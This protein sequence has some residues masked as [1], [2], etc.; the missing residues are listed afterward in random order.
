MSIKWYA[1]D[2]HLLEEKENRFQQRKKPNCNAVSM[3]VFADPE[4]SAVDGRNLRAV[5]NLSKEDQDFILT[6]L[7]VTKCGPLQEVGMILGQMTLF[8]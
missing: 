7:S 6:H 1:W 2:Q 4:R 5:G 8:S 3:E